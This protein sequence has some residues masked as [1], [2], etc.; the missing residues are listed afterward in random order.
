MNCA[1]QMQA[2]GT[3]EAP[4]ILDQADGKGHNNDNCNAA[5]GSD[6]DSFEDTSDY[7]S[8]GDDGGFS[9]HEGCGS[10]TAGA[11]QVGALGVLT[12]G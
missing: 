12:C 3:V 1:M 7:S 10:P 9:D 2:L 4:I 8:D 5:V 11:T 6:S